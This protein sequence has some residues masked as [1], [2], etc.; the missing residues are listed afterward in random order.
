[1]HHCSLSFSRCESDRA[2]FIEGLEQNYERIAASDH[3][4][5]VTCEVLEKAAGIEVKIIGT[6]LT[7]F[8]KRSEFAK[9]WRP[10]HFDVGEKVDARVIKFDN[11]ARKVE[12]S[13][14]ALDLQG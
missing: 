12:V 9:D 4:A 11:L 2:R 6:D 10:E 14:N 1:M 3:G 8:I 7:T 5:V 13:I